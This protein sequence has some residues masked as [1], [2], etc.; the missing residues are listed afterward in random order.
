MGRKGLYDHEGAQHKQHQIP[1]P[2]VRNLKADAFWGYTRSSVVAVDNFEAYAT[3]V[4]ASRHNANGL[5]L[6]VGGFCFNICA[7]VA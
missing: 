7:I 4:R 5:D 3:E 1:P 2:V 6:A